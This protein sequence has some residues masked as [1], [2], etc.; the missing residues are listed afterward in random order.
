MTVQPEARREAE[1]I[2]RVQR[3]DTSA[4]EE[5]LLPY[6]AL[7]HHLARRLRLSFLPEDELVQAG[8]VGMMRAAERFDASK[9]VR[10][11]TYAVPWALGEMRGALRRATDGGVRMLSM[12]AGEEGAS[13]GDILPGGEIDV[14]AVSLRHA[15]Q[16]L[17][18][19]ERE[20]IILRFFRD[21][22]QQEAARSL[23]RS[24]AQ[25]SRLERQTLDK[26]RQLL[27]D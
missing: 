11:I 5:L 14:E 27:K 18:A 19:Q 2:G 12:E 22:T 25:V 13:L 1:L 21:R 16:S 10:F 4:Y 15:L 23:G 7:L 20:L 9:A 6:R 3:G 26:L 8:Y 17:S 24:Q